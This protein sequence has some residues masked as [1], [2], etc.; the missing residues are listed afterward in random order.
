MKRLLFACAALFMT[1]CL[2]MRIPEGDELLALRDYQVGC[3]AGY[4]PLMASMGT[5]PAG[6]ECQTLEDG[7]ICVKY[8]VD[9][10]GGAGPN[11]DAGWITVATDGEFKSCEYLQNED[12]IDRVEEL[13]S[14]TS[15]YY[16]A[17]GRMT[18]R[19][20]RFVPPDTSDSRVNIIA[21]QRCTAEE[22]QPGADTLRIHIIDVANGDSIW[23]QTPTGQNVLIDGGEVANSAGLIITDYL[24]FHGFPKG[25][26]FDA[27]FLTHP[28][29]DHFGG[30]PALFDNY[31]IK[32]YID[33]METSSA[34]DVSQSYGR[35]I[36]K[37][38][39]MVEPG[40]LWMP[41]EET[42]SHDE[43]MPED[44]F[45][46]DVV[47]EYLFSRKTFVAA[48]GNSANPNTASIIFRLTY[49]GIS[50]LFTGD[51]TDVDETAVIAKAKNRLASNFLKVCHHGSDTSSTKPFLDAIFNSI[52][53]R[54]RGAF[55]SSGRKSFSGTYIPAPTTLNRLINDKYVT[56]EQLLSTSAGDD[57]K[58]E[59]EAFRDD[60]ILIVVK[61]SGQYYYCY[62]GTN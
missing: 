34:N 31:K 40:H 52:T 43:P 3:P 29:S 14:L 25:S 16:C 26:T 56:L 1:G 5:C 37:V 58:V 51:A 27:V 11:C 32:N 57:A 44:F 61:P 21:G 30:F 62:S 8:Q 59:S 28:H 19:F 48:N 17:P 45:G 13:E 39:A 9:T 60:N 47:A 38:S 50:M 23:I 2:D 55:I 46:P 20:C 42:L 33:P 6:E 54:D 10:S 24:E 53:D 4:G 49:K 35:W 22:S 12:D 15:G 41:A 7:Q 18:G 36:T